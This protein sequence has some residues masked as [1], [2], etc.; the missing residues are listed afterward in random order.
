MTNT[1]GDVLKR[2]RERKRCTVDDVYKSIKI[3]PVYIRA[4][5][6]D[7][8]TVFSG[9][10]HSKG[11]LKIYAEFLGLNVD[12]ILAFWRREHEHEFDRK[13]KS[14]MVP[15]RFIEPPK[16]LITPGA[17]LFVLIAAGLLAFFGYLYYQYRNFTGAPKLDLY[18]PSDNLVIQ[19]DVLDITGKTDLDSEV[20]V[21]DRRVVLA[22][23]GSFAESVRLKRGSNTLSIRAVNKYAKQTEYIRTV[24]FNPESKI[25]TTETSESTQATPSVH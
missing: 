24:V 15:R 13:E 22:P 16:F 21:N 4:L 8:Y 12:E 25:Q 14:Q 5:E 11:F 3:H 18:Y 17:L 23:D 19:T 7:N 1:I 20:Y 6:S 10:V 2:A 9:K